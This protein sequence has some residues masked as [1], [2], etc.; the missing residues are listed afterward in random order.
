MVGVG[1]SNRLAPTKIPRRISHL[2][3]SPTSLVTVTT[4]K[5]RKSGSRNRPV[6]PAVATDPAL[7]GWERA[8]E[9][10]NDALGDYWVRRSP[11]ATAML[12]LLNDVLHDAT[13]ENWDAEFVRKVE[14]AIGRY[15]AAKSSA[16]VRS[17]NDAKADHNREAVRVAVEG[18]A[19]TPVARPAIEPGSGMASSVQV[20]LRTGVPLLGSMTAVRL[21]LKTIRSHLRALGY[22]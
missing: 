16:G 21:S 7:V 10:I 11:D 18:W 6:G 4:Q 17:A 3:R 19:D 9:L 20:R 12:A 2:G 1:R 22:R 5:L 15:H 13:P 14:A 8:R